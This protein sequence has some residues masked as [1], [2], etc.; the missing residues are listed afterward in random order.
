MNRTVCCKSK[1]AH[2]A[3]SLLAVTSAFLRPGEL[4]AQQSPTA[5]SEVDNIPGAVRL[6]LPPTI[7][8][9]VGREMNVYFDNV[10]L[11][12]N[13]DKYA[14]D[15]TCSRGRQQAD[16]WTYTLAAMEVGAVPFQLE[17]RNEQNE[18]IA[19]AR[20]E[21][22]VVAAENDAKPVSLLAIGDSLTHASVYP[23]RLVELCSE[24][25]PELTLVGSFGPGGVP[26]VIRHE[27]YGG[28]TA[29]RFATHYRETARQGDYKD[30]GSPF[31]YAQSEGEPKLDF[32]RYC[33]D[34]NEG[35]LPDVVTIFLG[36]NDVFGATDETIE[37][38]IDEMLKHYDELIAM[39]RQ[40][41][42]EPC[43]A[44]MLPVP[45][46]ASQD[47]FGANYA[48]GQTRWQYKRNQ[49]R[50]VERMMTAYGSREAERLY[51]VPT[52]INLDCRRNYPT[53]AINPEAPD[54]SGR[55]NN[56]VHPA[57]AGYR[58]IG[59]TLYAWLAGRK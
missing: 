59:D 27:G 32:A 49:H 13:S 10:V 7:Y 25:G 51:L 53:S 19:R 33:Q 42:P 52:Y 30:R 44:A 39:I 16:R 48:S 20:C 15:V 21:L 1:F 14:F 24:S 40:A 31:L 23:K 11:A 4:R 2:C 26:G 18:L 8:A 35:R 46:A 45:P 37:S 28:W 47:A 58:Q 36:P 17:V 3:L 57:E 29:K 43:I 41:G 50:L 54:Q 34:V 55:Q 22:R 6:I 5:C 38:V 9:V 12:L 56:G